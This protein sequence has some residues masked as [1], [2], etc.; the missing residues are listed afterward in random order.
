MMTIRVSSIVLILL[1]LLTGCATPPVQPDGQN[2]S[3]LITPTDPADAAKQFEAQER[4]VEA[5]AEY[6]RLARLSTPPAQQSYQLSGIEAYL[7]ANRLAEA[8]AELATLNTNQG[9]ALELPVEFVHIRI[10]LSEQQVREAEQRWSR[11]NAATVPKEWQSKY[12]LLKPEMMEAN[13]KVI[14]AARERV[15]LSNLLATEPRALAENQRKLWNSLSALPPQTLSKIATTPGDTFSGWVA[16]AALAKNTLAKRLPAVVNQ[17]Q[18][19]YPGHPAAATI[20]QEIVAQAQR[21]PQMKQIALLL[22][23]TGNFKPQAEAVQNGFLAASY[24]DQR[25]ERP[26]IELYNAT[27][28]DVLETYQK[29]I[30]SGA[31][32]VVGPLQKEAVTTLIHQHPQRLPVLTLGLNYAENSNLTTRNLYQ[33]GLAPEDEAVEVARQA[34]RDGHRIALALAPEGAWGERV[35]DTFVKEWKKQG[36]QVARV[37]YFSENLTNAAKALATLKDQ[38]NMIFMVAF[39]KHARQ[40]QPLFKSYGL[41]TPIY[42]TSHVFYGIPDPRLDQDSDGIMFVD[43]PWIVSPDDYAKQLQTS[44]KQSFPDIHDTVQLKRLY[45][46]GVDAYQLLSQLRQENVQPFTQT[47]GQ[48]GELVMDNIGAIHRQKLRWAKFINGVPQLLGVEQRLP[49]GQ[50]I[51]IPAMEMTPPTESLPE[52]APAEALPPS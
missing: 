12:L 39:P 45:A 16:L 4:Y 15:N 49:V 28:S 38:A 7:N 35:I 43:M 51:Q 23:V 27:P 26:K 40:L 32:Y 50:P 25:V 24:A 14:D 18:V 37:E 42:S 2:Q 11:I 5:A 31:D 36:G 21:T 46:F 30:Q 13:G 47:Q 1:S 9:Y 52:S 34:W 19:Q 20:A 29:A 17:W 33:F 10:A 44:L 41:E 22:P 8:K 6:L 3:Q 48:T